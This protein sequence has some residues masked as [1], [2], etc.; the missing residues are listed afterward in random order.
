M[1]VGGM[2]SIIGINHLAVWGA[3]DRYRIKHPVRCFEKV[4]RVF[5]DVTMELVQ[6]ED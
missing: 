2:G 4:L 5:A 6:G 1:I 3:I